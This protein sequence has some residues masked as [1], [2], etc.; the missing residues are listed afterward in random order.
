[1]NMPRKII[2]L[3][4]RR[5]RWKLLGLLVLATL[6]GLAQV[7]G[8]GS[9]MPLFDGHLAGVVIG[10]KG[11]LLVFLVKVVVYFG[12]D[13]LPCVFPVPGQYFFWCFL[14]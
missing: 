8:I 10:V 5:E 9:V 1:M 7:M 3:L 12:A 13:A 2:G 11:A 14:S 4:D 6:S